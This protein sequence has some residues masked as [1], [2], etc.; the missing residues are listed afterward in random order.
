MRGI[1]LEFTP[2]SRIRGAHPQTLWG[3]LVTESPKLQ[4][5][6]ELLPSREGE[7]LALDWYDFR[8]EGPLLVV[9]HGLEG[10]SRAP[11]V[12]RLA[13]Q[14][15]R[16]GMGVVALNARGCGG[17]PNETLQSYHASWTA[18]LEVVV[19]TLAERFPGRPLFLVGYSLGGSQFG[20]YL[21][22]CASRV[23]ATVRGAYLISTPIALDR[24]IG[25]LDRG[26]NKMYTTKFLGSLGRK[27]LGKAVRHPEHRWRALRAA[28]AGTVANF[29]EVWTAPVH[30]FENA[31]DYY[32]RSSCASVLEK[33]RVPV[34]FLN[35][36]DDPVVPWG[37][38]DG[39]WLDSNPRVQLMRTR[40]GGHVGFVDET[41]PRW[42]EQQILAQ[43]EL[44]NRGLPD[45]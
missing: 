40:L 34:V 14:A 25:T 42:L 45:S 1:E 11:Y 20:N 17:S 22:R 30:G 4:Y 16:A 6:R 3:Y 39:E 23:P 24:A 38:V 27:M 5:R 18:D 33:I 29:D 37:A 32:V 31:E 35:A 13:D 15:S 19:E 8:T 10:R 7:L 9:Q 41:T 26:W 44:W 36:E 43:I 12:R 21:G 2:P 28:F